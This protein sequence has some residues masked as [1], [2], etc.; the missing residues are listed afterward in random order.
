MRHSPI[1]A[2]QRQERGEG[3]ERGGGAD[4][5]REG[6]TEGIVKE[7]GNTGEM[8]GG[9][10]RH[11]HRARAIVASGS[12]AGA[13]ARWE[14]V[15]SWGISGCVEE[16]ALRFTSSF[17][18][19]LWIA[20]RG[21]GAWSAAS[22]VA[23]GGRTAE[24]GSG[25]GAEH[26]GP[27]EWRAPRGRTA[28]AHA[29]DVLVSASERVGVGGGYR[30]R[31]VG[32]SQARPRRGAEQRSRATIRPRVASNRGVDVEDRRIARGEPQRKEY[33]RYT[34]PPVSIYPPS[35]H[36]FGAIGVGVESPVLEGD[37]VRDL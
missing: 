32:E 26:L 18:D 13:G 19:R 4:G 1:S 21:V 16:S 6:G 23:R 15:R 34:C 36:S 27:A 8:V 5:G 28:G 14:S 10:H 7:E 31:L 37:K 35:L 30:I 9:R 2:H 29:P 22:R 33:L 24:L 11:R 3:S 25:A 12:G 17:P 20:Q